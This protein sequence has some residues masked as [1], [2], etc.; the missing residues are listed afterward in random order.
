MGGRIGRRMV[1]RTCGGG[2]GGVTSLP[3]CQMG[4]K[5]GGEGMEEPTAGLSLRKAAAVASAVMG[6]FE[7]GRG[8]ASWHPRWSGNGG[9]SLGR[10][11]LVRRLRRLRLVVVVWGSVSVDVGLLRG[12]QRC[13]RSGRG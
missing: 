8:G 6:V 4:W 2:G 12:G 1:G 7:W 5:C 3:P 9:G 10:A 11:R 13:C